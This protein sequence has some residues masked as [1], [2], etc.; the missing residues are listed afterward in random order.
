FVPVRSPQM[1]HPKTKEQVE[2]ERLWRF[3]GKDESF[4]DQL[5]AVFCE[6]VD[7]ASSVILI[8]ESGGNADTWR[9]LGVWPEAEETKQRFSSQRA[10]LFQFADEVLKQGDCVL[11][12]QRLGESVLLGV[13]PLR[14][15]TDDL[16]C[17]IAFL[18]YGEEDFFEP[19][20][21]QLALMVD[22]PLIY[23]AD[24]VDQ[25]SSSPTE[26]E[27]SVNPLS[28]AVRMGIL[29]GEEKRFVPGAMTL[30]NELASQ[31]NA[32]RVSFGSVSGHDVKVKATSGAEKV[33]GQMEA[34]KWLVAAME[35]STDQDDE[36]V[37]PAAED[38]RVIYRDHEF[39]AKKTGVAA[40]VSLPL[41]KGRK[42]IGA[43]SLERDEPFEI[44]E[45]EL[46]R[47]TADLVAPRL[48]DLNQR[49]RWFGARIGA[50]FMR[51]LRTVFGLDHTLL[52][53]G[54]VLTAAA[55]AFLALFPWTYRVKAPFTL[56]AERVFH[57]PAP[58][59]GY[60]SESLV[61]TGDQVSEGDVLF[62][63]DATEFDLK[64][65]E[66]RA[67][68]DRAMAEVQAA[69]SESAPAKMHVAMAQ[70]QEAKSLLENAVF[71]KS[72]ASVVAPQEGFVIEGDL[73]KKIGSP[74]TKGEPLI[75]LSQLDG[76][77]AEL[78]VSEKDIRYVKSDSL[79]EVA[80]TGRPEV[81]FAVGLQSIDPVAIAEEDGAVLI[82]RAEFSDDGAEW[83][84]PGM[85]GVARIDCGKR[86]LLWI[87]SHR[88][89]DYLRLKLWL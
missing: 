82:V 70:A 84:R 45:I 63:M 85:S 18:R 46:L 73:E 43:L 3:D 14:L 29:L 17:V 62:S 59:E 38:S 32:E 61:Q 36:I 69:R 10:V 60:I 53:F 48:N 58:F 35:E 65:A 1:P 2:L 79:G 68:I 83:W 50:A 51:G 24:P 11:E 75:Q 44:H 39:Y 54:L 47:V 20:D 64:I 34:S 4:W 23:G 67:A 37:W 86:S 56:E 19:S 9:F 89:I 22:S 52:K 77:Y 16:E 8:R 40:L 31:F 87:F 33:S 76:M 15:A 28:F 12:K 41:R 25:L 81:P 74:V 71:Q 6:Q 78:K 13:L 26:S 7:A 21:R 57:I 27:S 88:A 49:D 66:Q 5:M 72:K 55:V 30:C 80:F 42:R